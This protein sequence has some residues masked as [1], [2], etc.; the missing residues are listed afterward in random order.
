MCPLA[1]PGDPVEEF[2]SK[3]QEERSKQEGSN[4]SQ[5]QVEYLDD[6]HF[7][8]S[9]CLTLHAEASILSLNGTHNRPE[10]QRIQPLR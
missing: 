6:F 10:M 3:P 8:P 1:Q 2:V 4:R 5:K 9:N 7:N